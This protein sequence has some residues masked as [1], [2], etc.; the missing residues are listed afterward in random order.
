MFLKELEKVLLGGDGVED[1]KGHKEG[2]HK[3]LV[4]HIRQRYQ[5]KLIPGPDVQIVGLHRKLQA[6]SHFLKYFTTNQNIR[7]NII[8][9][10][11]T[12]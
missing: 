3:A 10:L 7:I 1:V 4:L 2:E 8:I 6:Y 12:A 11:F 5:H 9:M